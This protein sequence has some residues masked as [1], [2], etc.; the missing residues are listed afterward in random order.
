MK[1]HDFLSTDED[2]RAALD[3][4]CKEA[5]AAFAEGGA[6]DLGC[7]F[8]TPHHEEV[9]DEVAK[10]I[11]EATGVR[12]LIGCTAESVIAGKREIERVAG[13]SLWLASMPGTEIQSFHLTH[14]EDADGIGIDGL[15]EQ[16]AGRDIAPVAEDPPLMILF[17]DP[18]SFPIDAMIRELNE[19]RRGV[20]IVGGMASGALAAGQNRLY[21]DGATIREGAVGV[22][23]SGGVRFRTVVSQGCRP[24]GRRALITGANENLISELGGVPSKECLISMLEEV[25]DEERHLFEKAPHIGIAIDEYRD[26]FERGDFLIRNILGWDLTGALAVNDVVRRGQTIQFHVRD[27]DSA[28]EDLE[29]LL[30]TEGTDGESAPETALLFSCNGRGTRLFADPDHDVSAVRERGGDIPIAGFFAGGEIGPVGDKNF[31]HGF[32]ASVVLLS[33]RS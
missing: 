28:R 14:Q 29:V 20:P 6:P 4:V 23:L 33:S 25:S 17:A 8:V 9:L 15:P 26:D 13:I 10:R 24:I 31:L 30:E 1:V 11:T 22:L 19:T 16:L 12:H 27:A 3:A 7:V 21:R 2:P 5:S 32:T 18:Y